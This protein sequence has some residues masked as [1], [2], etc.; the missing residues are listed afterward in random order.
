MTNIANFSMI[1]LCTV[2]ILF[3]HNYGGWFI[4]QLRVDLLHVEGVLSVYRVF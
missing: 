4:I 1:L 3:V 2:F